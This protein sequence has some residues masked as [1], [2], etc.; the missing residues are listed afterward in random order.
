MEV[1][2]TRVLRR[3]PD[4]RHEGDLETAL[5]LSR[6]SLKYFAEWYN[7]SALAADAD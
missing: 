4:G 5:N 2:R 3:I 7:A 6:D 1:L